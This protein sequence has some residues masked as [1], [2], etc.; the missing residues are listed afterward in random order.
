MEEGQLVRVLFCDGER[1]EQDGWLTVY[2]PGGS[3]GLVPDAYLQ[4][5]MA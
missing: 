4:V 3:V 1:Y 2:G 5:V